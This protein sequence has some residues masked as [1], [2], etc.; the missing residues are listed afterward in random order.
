MIKPLYHGTPL[1]TG[2]ANLHTVPLLQTQMLSPQSEPL[3][4]GPNGSYLLVCP[5]GLHADSAAL[6]DL[7][8]VP[9]CC[10]LCAK[11]CCAEP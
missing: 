11:D 6:V 4:R 10:T 8:A 7:K 2:E 1:H 5:A 3:A 9:V